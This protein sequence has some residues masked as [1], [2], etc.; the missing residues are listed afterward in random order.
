MSFVDRGQSSSTQ[1]SSASRLS[2]PGS[3][4]PVGPL[5]LLLPLKQ[6]S[7]RAAV[8]TLAKA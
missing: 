7:L 4:F 2:P 8:T 3:H 6:Q 5:S 1:S